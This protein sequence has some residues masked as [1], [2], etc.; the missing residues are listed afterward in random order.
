MRWLTLGWLVFLECTPS[1][2]DDSGVM[3][4]SGPCASSAGWTY[5]AAGGHLSCGVHTD[6]CAECW[7]L[8]G[9]VS[10]EDPYKSSYYDF[11]EQVPPDVAFQ[12]ISLVNFSAQ[13]WGNQACGLTADNAAVCWGRDDAGQATA[14][15]G[16]FLQVDVAA[17]NSCGLTTDGAVV[18]W[19]DQESPALETTYQ[20]IALG[21][22]AGMAI[23]TS[24]DLA[25][26]D[27]FSGSVLYEMDGPVVDVAVSVFGCAVWD[28]GTLD[29]WFPDDPS[30][31]SY[32]TVPAGEFVSV[33]AGHDFA[34]AIGRDGLPVCFSYEDRHPEIIAAPEIALTQVS[35]GVEHACGVTPDHAIVCWGEDR[36]GQAT[37]PE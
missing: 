4:D 35:C 18:M 28:D 2:D 31:L 30:G 32:P 20:A 27:S 9:L 6:G 15:E 34:C 24:G 13:N 23:E 14:P 25:V 22:S 17:F 12:T 26:W 3:A 16:S 37:P 33:C 19:G 8:D 1:K 11:G 5:V 36:Y 7:G 29:C 21:Y 10:G